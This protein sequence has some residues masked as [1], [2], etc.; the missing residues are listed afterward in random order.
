MKLS[1][2]PVSLFP[3]LINGEM[4]LYAW[5]DSAKKMGLDAVDMSI[6]FLRSRTR[7][8]ILRAKEALDRAGMTVAMI[9]TYPDFTDPSPEQ[10]RR[11]IAHA[12]SDIAAA[13]ELGASYV[14]ITAGQERPGDVQKTLEYVVECF[15]SCETFARDAGVELLYENHAKPGAWD[16][17]D[18]DFDT[19][20]FLR[21]F[22]M[23][24]NLDI[25]INFDTAN[26][27]G[28]GDDPIPVFKTVFP[29]V[30]SIHIA[31]IHNRGNMHYSEIGKGAA[32]IKEILGLAKRQG[33]DGLISI[34]EASMNGLNGIADAVHTVKK[35]WEC[36]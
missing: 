21:L 31:D 32:P 33:F 23:T 12:N 28:F 16:R 13:A 2:L 35:I 29:K 10:R 18:F 11:E 34:E 17:P 9:T 19:S 5:A 20:V 30:K 8:E 24:R 4:D 15:S 3:A 7:R 1:C 27:L 22:Q 26:T 36:I 25:G 14:R 6:L